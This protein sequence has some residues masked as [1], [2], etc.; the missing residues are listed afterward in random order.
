MSLYGRV[1]SEFRDLREPFLGCLAAIGCSCTKSSLPDCDPSSSE[2]DAS[3]AFKLDVFLCLVFPV[4]KAPRGRQLLTKLSEIGVKPQTRELK[5][6]TFRLAFDRGSRHF[7]LEC[8]IR[9]KR[10]RESYGLA[11]ECL[12]VEEREDSP[13]AKLNIE[14][15]FLDI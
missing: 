7:W 4:G 11:S 6:L 14:M 15:Y 5:L 12:G 9:W 10:L 3:R 13:V 8:V 2:S 1:G